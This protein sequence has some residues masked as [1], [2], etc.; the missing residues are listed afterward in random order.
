MNMCAHTLFE[1][2]A[3]GI[4]CR[5][6]DANVGGEHGEGARVSVAR[7]ALRDRRSHVG[8]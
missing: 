6:S 7:E 1:Y 3:A 8:R 2:L 4:L 5:S